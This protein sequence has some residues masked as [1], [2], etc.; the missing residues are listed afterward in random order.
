MVFLIM[1]PNIVRI[2]IIVSFKI[3]QEYIEKVLCINKNEPII[4]CRGKCYLVEQL[5]KTEEHEERD[6]STHKKERV[7]LVYH[8]F[9]NVYPCPGFLES[10]VLKLNPSYYCKDYAFDYPYDF[11]RPPKFVLV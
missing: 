10:Q 4:T 3:N 6:A 2:G 5:Q 1:I 11:F 8:L 7:E 9:K